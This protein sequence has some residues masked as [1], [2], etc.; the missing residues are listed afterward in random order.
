[1]K[2]CNGCGLDL[3]EDN[4]AKSSSKK[5]GF[6]SRC[7]SCKHKA[8][9]ANRE[10]R[11]SMAKA[12]IERNR[13]EI[14]KKQRV[15]YAKRK[16]SINEIR[17]AKR[18]ESPGEE[19][20]KQ[21]LRRSDVKQKCIDVLGGRC[22]NCG[23]ADIDV[24]C[25]DHVNDDGQAERASGVISISIFRRIVRKEQLDRYQ[26][27]CFNCNL[28]KSILRDRSGNPT[29]VNKK[30]PTC[31]LTKDQSAFK[32]DSKYP[33]GRYYECR[34]CD[35][36]RVII[37]K[38]QAMVKLGRTSCPCGHD[39]VLTL[40]FDHVNDDGVREYGL[41]RSLYTAIA[42]G[43][44]GGSRYQVL[45][46]NCNLKKYATRRS[47][48]NSIAGFSTVHTTTVS[49]PI[50]DSTPIEPFELRDLVISVSDNIPEVVSFMELNHY[51]GYG[52]GGSLSFVIKHNETI[53]AA[54]KFASPVRK[55]VAGSLNLEYKEVFELDRFCIAKD[56]HVKNLA[57][58]VLSRI[59]KV[60]P[61]IR[62]EITHVVSFADPEYGHNGTIYLSSNW[63][64]LGYG[65]RS[66][67]Y[68]DGNGKKIHK[69]TVYNAAKSRGMRELEFAE[70]AG[71]KR[72][73]VV[74]KRKFL[75]KL[76]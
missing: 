14:L 68:I 55:E 50:V 4:F 42:N 52:R 39:D 19:A 46:M 25:V 61:K 58:Y 8:Y 45:C 17:R 48:A 12:R 38:T 43:Q 71:Y 29:G 33:D 11:I 41:G 21:R 65:A 22:K 31:S 35:R 73:Y 16:D 37:V 51:A 10:K 32:R 56:C 1:M 53:V 28:R 74:A 15:S 30:C 60:I 2:H 69:K 27:L 57:S 54:A 63:K 34:A 7:K 5:D 75:Y 64:D 67:Q 40:S 59:L 36:N 9:L 3:S 76:R 70:S 47:V 18:A 66:Y 44:V 49:R 26:I 72:S 6:E 24:L 62:P 23:A 20:A 13:E